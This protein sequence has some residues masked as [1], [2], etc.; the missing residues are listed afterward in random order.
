MSLTVEFREDRSD[1]MNS[2]A[3]V[4]MMANLIAQMAL[5][6]L[7]EQRPQ[8]NVAKLTTASPS[9][10]PEHTSAAK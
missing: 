3:A 6:R 4:E 1:A 5:K 10:V 2:P 9:C 7:A 8:S